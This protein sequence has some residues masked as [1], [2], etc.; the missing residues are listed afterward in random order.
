LAGESEFL[1][2][3]SAV[4]DGGH[5]TLYLPDVCGSACDTIPAINFSLNSRSLTLTRLFSLDS[6]KVRVDSYS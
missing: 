5:S 2:F 4:Y 3:G 1:Y 6:T